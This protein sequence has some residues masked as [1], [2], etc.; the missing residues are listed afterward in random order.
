MIDTI[1]IMLSKDDFKITNHNAFTPSTQGF[2]SH[3]FLPMNRGFFSCIQNASAEDKKKGIY[4]PQLTITKRI[5]KG[6]HKLS[7][8]IQFSAPKLLYGNNFDELENNDK[9]KVLKTLQSRLLEMGIEISFNKL[10]LA[11]LGV[12]HYGK[13][14]ILNTGSVSLV[15]R[16]IAKMNISKRL[17]Y[18]QNRFS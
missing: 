7:L 16:M 3:P 17:V 12:V 9:E 11:E 5:R 10:L 18:K 1:A 6:G 4:K 2:F 14:I 13:N 8:K 15:N